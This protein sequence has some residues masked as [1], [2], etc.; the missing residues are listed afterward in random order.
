M[1]Y[2]RAGYR[3]KQKLRRRRKDE[4]RLAAK[5]EA[6]AQ[7]PDL[8]GTAKRAAKHVAAAVEQG[9]ERVKNAVTRKGPA[10]KEPG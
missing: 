9:A 8:L 6:P 1:G 4:R 7:S 10:P 3:A 2:N 5:G